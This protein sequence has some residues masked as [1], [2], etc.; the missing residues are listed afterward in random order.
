MARNR[1]ELIRKVEGASPAGDFDSFRIGDTVDVHLAVKEG[2]KDRIQV[3]SGLVIARSGSGNSE[4]F[5]VRRV[6]GDEGVERIFPVKSPSIKAV[7]LARAGKVRRAK[8]FYIRG[9]AG[10]RARI[11]E[12]RGEIPADASAPAETPENNAPQQEQS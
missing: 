7:K 4:S 11:A 3:F 9:R 2:D 5:T 6:V 12:R 8:L 10:R 1:Q